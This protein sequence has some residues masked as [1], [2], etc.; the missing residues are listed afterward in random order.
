[1]R[2]VVQRV[3]EASVTIDG[4]VKS[5]IGKGLLLLIGIE[6]ADSNDDIVWLCNKIVNLR[7]FDDADAVPN[8]SVK[9]IQGDILVISQFTLHAST[10]KGNRPSYIRASKPP[11]AIPL[12]EAF[13]HQLEKEL[14][15]PVGCGEF[16]ADMKVQLINDGPVTIIIDTKNK[17]F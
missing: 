7:I 12:Y 9:D 1:M 10:K 17:D 8:I 11:V 13:L 2:T 4:K 3:S 15:K 5:T 6:D 14:G 16:G